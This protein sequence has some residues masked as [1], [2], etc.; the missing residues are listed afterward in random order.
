MRARMLGRVMALGLAVTSTVACGDD[1]S[2]SGPTTTNGSATSSTTPDVS[3]TT[4][5]DG[6]GL[7]DGEHFGYLVE[8]EAR[9]GSYEGSFDLA[10]VY[11]GNEAITRAA[12]DGHV[13]E[14]EF[15]VRNESPKLRGIE[16]DPAAEIRD[17]D[18]ER[19]C[20]PR[21]VT[22]A[23]FVRSRDELG[24]ARTAV[25]LTVEGG[26]VIAVEEQYFP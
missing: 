18:P 26:L 11:S 21:D 12:E 9:D 8:L 6:E 15:Y 17:I 3:S 24:E 5:E 1:D 20:E 13:L 23:E 4:P 2:S 22:A 14:T 19:C 16:L 10:Y 7:P 25:H